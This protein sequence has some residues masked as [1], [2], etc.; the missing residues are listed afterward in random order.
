MTGVQTCALPISGPSAAGALAALLAVAAA[1]GCTG[2]SP[3][4]PAA[5][6]ATSSAPASV[7]P[8]GVSSSAA[9]GNGAHPTTI[10]GYYAQTL[11]WTPCD[12]Y[13]QCARLSVPFDYAHPAGPAFSLP[14]VKL[15]AAKPAERIGALVINPG[16]PEIGRAH[17]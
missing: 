17:V 4:R 11:A 6:S 7:G 15:P 8:A 16:G 13:F 5:T 1:A 12:T 3:P 2:S 14:V 10:A 9:P